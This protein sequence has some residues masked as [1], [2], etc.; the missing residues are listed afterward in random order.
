MVIEL[1]SVSDTNTLTREPDRAADLEARFQTE[2]EIADKHGYY[3]S[4]LSDDEKVA[5]RLA[6]SCEGFDEEIHLLK[7][8]IMSMQVLHP[9]NFSLLGRF[10][11]LLERL[12]KTQARLFRK[13]PEA[14]SQKKMDD[15]S[16]RLSSS[17]GAPM[18]RAM[19][20]AMA[21]G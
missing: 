18:N 3:Y 7:T 4:V 13:G 10:I 5:Y 1:D 8:K 21:R 19:R 14:D 6:A 11:A 17:F 9:L 2:K 15:V 20:R 16:N 12:I